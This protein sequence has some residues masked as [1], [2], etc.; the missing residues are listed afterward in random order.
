MV[1]VHSLNLGILLALRC[2][3]ESLTGIAPS[4]APVWGN[5]ELPLRTLRSLR[6][7]PQSSTALRILFKPTSERV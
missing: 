2:A 3:T 7:E 1:T 4:L 6:R 5:S